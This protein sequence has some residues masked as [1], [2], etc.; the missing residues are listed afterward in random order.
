MQHARTTL[1]PSLA[2]AALAFSLSACSSG[3]AEVPIERYEAA[4]FA[5]LCDALV[6]CVDP[7]VFGDDGFLRLTVGGATSI[8]CEEILETSGLDVRQRE[9]AASIGAG[10]I[11]YD[12]AAARAC[13]DA[14]RTSCAPLVA[15]EAIDPSCAAMIVG[16]VPLTETCTIDEDCEGDARCDKTSPHACEGVCVGLSETGTACFTSETCTRAVPG[17]FATCAVS[18]DDPTPHCVATTLETRAVR[19][20][21]C[22]AFDQGTDAPRVVRCEPSLY[23][24]VVADDVGTCQAPIRLGAPC[25]PSVDVCEGVAVCIGEGGDVPTC[26]TLAIQSEDGASCDPSALEICNPL[27]RLACGDDLRCHL[28]GTGELGAACIEGNLRSFCNPGLYCDTQAEAPTCVPTKPDGE[29][30]S[31]DDQCASGDCDA[32][33]TPFVCSPS[34]CL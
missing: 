10:R 8:T 13:F 18:V 11:A 33:L 20:M 24:R 22:G 28:V 19:D 4:Y 21:P 26:R 7:A 5:S 14:M 15:L 25:V 2:F 3:S 34:M 32:A 9:I 29:V 27:D 23:C 17:A 31:G 12:P 30:C 1:P 6:G 16:T